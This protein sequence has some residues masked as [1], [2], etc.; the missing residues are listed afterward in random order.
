MSNLSISNQSGLP[1]RTEMGSPAYVFTPA[2]LTLKLVLVL[3]LATFGIVG[4]VGNLFMYYFISWK[5]QRVPYFTSNQFLRILNFYLK[6]LAISDM[7][8]NIISL[9]LLCTDIMFDVFQHSWE[10]RIVRF[11]DILFS[12]IT[13]N[14][15][16]V[17]SVERYLATRS[18]PRTFNV[19]SARKLVFG[20]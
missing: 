16:I 10:C 1:N 3:L 4:F 12:S 18:I 8:S 5:K 14:N 13:M 11:L 19:S 9:P 15:L 2:G 17:I 20:A 7:L 6:S